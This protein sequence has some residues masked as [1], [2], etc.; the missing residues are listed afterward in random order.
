MIMMRRFAGAVVLLLATVGT[1]CCVA[2]IIGTWTFCQRAP[3]RV[4]KVAAG[5]DAALQRALD[6]TQNAR[7]AV[8]NARAEVAR[9]AKEPPERADG[10]TN[11]RGSRALRTLLQQR[12]GPNLNDLS[13]RLATLSD[14]A[15][16][17][18]ALLQSFE[19]LPLGRMD[20]LQPDQ[21]EEW[22]SQVQ[23]LSAT[24]RQ[25]EA[26]VGEGDQEPS[27]PDVAAATSQVDLVLERCQATADGWQSS[28]DGAR[29]ELA[30]ARTL[31]LRWLWPAGILVMLLVGWVALGQ[32]SLFAHG[33]QWCRPQAG[34]G[35]SGIPMN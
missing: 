16:A 15:V 13:G 21:L 22:R 34:K 29:D 20:H 26:A 24:L 32:I 23:H 27:G 30:R 12:V 6:A 28:L 8:A 18:A 10:G 9:V 1:V 17:V 7:R 35:P 2:G 5:L 25:L 3:E 31:I 19:G 33:L 11:R 4:E 14:G